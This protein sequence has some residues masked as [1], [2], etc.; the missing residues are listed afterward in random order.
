MINI[1][2]QDNQL[3]NTGATPHGD[4]L[5]N[6][7][8][9]SSKIFSRKIEF[10][11][12]D[13]ATRRD[14]VED[15]LDEM[16]VFLFGERLERANVL[17]KGLKEIMLNSADH[18][19]NELQININLYRDIDKKKVHLK[20]SLKDKG[21]GLPYEE[22][23]IKH[24]FTTGESHDN[25]QKK[26]KHNFGVGLG[27]IH[28]LAKDI[29]IDLVLHNKG[30]IIRLNDLGLQKNIEAQEDFGYEGFGIFNVV[31]KK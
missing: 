6:V 3:E 24:F 11:N 10:A 31:E 20:F 16:I 26:G 1:P 13:Y 8:Q 14:K 12:L 9:E 18:N 30:K 4:N 5:F 7:L 19:G 28:A 17:T 2:E 21:S 15:V 27:I 29:N 25:W 23:K 22:D